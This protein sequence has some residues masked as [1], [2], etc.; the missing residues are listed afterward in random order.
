M[1]KARYKKRKDGRYATTVQVGFDESGK[2]IRKKVYGKTISELENKVAR[3][4]TSIS[5]GNYSDCKNLTVADW[6]QKW[7]KIYKS[8]L[9]AGTY[10]GYFRTVKNHI[11]PQIG[12]LF[13]D[14]VKQYHIQSMVNILLDKG[15]RRAAE[16]TLLTIKQI[17]QKAIENNL[18]SVNVA[19]Y[20]RLPKIQREEKTVLTDTEKL[21]IRQAK[22]T[23]KQR[24]FL[25]LLYYTGI[26]RGEALA[27]TKSCVNLENKTITI[28]A[29]N[30]INHNSIKEPKSESSRRTIPIPET[31]FY[32]FKNYILN[33]DTEYVFPSATGCAMTKSAFRRFWED[34]IARVQKAADEISKNEKK[35]IAINFGCHKFRHSYAS[36]LFYAG[37][38]IKAAQ[39]LLGHKTI[40]MTLKIYTHF[41][42]QKI[43]I[44]NDKIN[45]F[46]ANSSL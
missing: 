12:N 17:L 43:N 7:L 27:L 16:Y 10:D 39:Y 34:I 6:S 21:C 4:K 31:F 35:S 5:D 36:N 15:E 13:L 25:N 33:I 40:E 24:N 2:S 32:A 11:N 30:D 46:F 19:A 20:V 3:L 1:P 18:I 14:K 38:D 8:N 41:D 9:S 23:D 37:V 42:N 45:T 28:V 44:A 29:S 26:R 22:L